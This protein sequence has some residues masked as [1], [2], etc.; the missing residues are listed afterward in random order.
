VSRLDTEAEWTNHGLLS[1]FAAS[2]F[3]LGR[4]VILERQ[5]AAPLIE[6]TESV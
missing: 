3:Q 2:G 6:P 1:F 4:R 5:V